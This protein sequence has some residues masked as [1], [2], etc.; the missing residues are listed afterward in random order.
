MTDVLSKL[1]RLSWRG[2]EYPLV[3]RSVNFAHE[4]AEHQFQFHDGQII[5][6]TG[7]KNWTFS[8]TIPFRQ[9]I[10]KGP[11]K[12]LFSEGYLAFVLAC[13]DR[14][15]DELIDPVLGTFRAVCTS[16]TEDMDVNKRDG[17]DV[18]VEFLHS[19]EID[20][21]AIGQLQG[22]LLGVSG[23]AG[24]AAELDQ[25][26]KVTPW[27]AQVPSPEPT[28]DPL[29]AISGFGQQI[30]NQGNKASAALD[31]IAYKA[32]LVEQSADRL[33]DPNSFQLKRSSRRVQASALR[34][35][36]RI[37]NPERRILRVTLAYG[38]SL[39]QVASDAGMTVEQLITLNPS[40]AGRP[41]IP[42]GTTLG[43]FQK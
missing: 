3:T 25:Q 24:D 22:G 20:D 28:T 7:A 19:P 5:E 35:K 8:Y 17:T 33:E 29:S 2:G 38:K 23:I 21:P 1:P 13:R 14:T 30:V 32:E 18:R 4:Q 36:D 34:L 31:N 6:R 40:I 39:S 12:N 15:P 43:V 37:E 42:G 10:A 11:Y 26:L 9:D 41:I 16:F 27:T